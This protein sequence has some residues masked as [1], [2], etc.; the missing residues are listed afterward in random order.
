MKS[1]DLFT[2]F[3]SA[4]RSKH[5]LYIRAWWNRI[6]WPELTHSL[7]PFVPDSQPSRERCHR[8]GQPR[9]ALPQRRLCQKKELKDN[10]KP[11][12]LLFI[13]A[14]RFIVVCCLHSLR[15][16]VRSHPAWIRLD[17]IGEFKMAV[18]RLIVVTRFHL[19]WKWAGH[20]WSWGKVRRGSQSSFLREALIGG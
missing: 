8:K 10:K 16:S 3:C 18:F 15:C 4:K 20:W 5:A 2:I 17:S 9:A 7:S 6:S 13:S 12:V 14:P 1:Y 19:K 11:T